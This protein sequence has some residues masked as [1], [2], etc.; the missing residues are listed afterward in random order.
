MP[1]I[2]CLAEEDLGS[3]ECFCSMELPGWLVSS[4]IDYHSSS[5]SFLATWYFG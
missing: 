5:P 2:S 3:Q 4:L 1:E